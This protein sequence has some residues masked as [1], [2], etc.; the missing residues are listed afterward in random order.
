MNWQRFREEYGESPEEHY[1]DPADYQESIGNVFE[2]NR[3]R[4]RREEEPSEGEEEEAGEVSEVHIRCCGCDKKIPIGE[5]YPSYNHPEA[6]P[7]CFD[8]LPG[9]IKK[10][11]E[12]KRRSRHDR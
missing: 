6:P 3:I 4:K 1:D 7:V 2:A 9:E 10:E 5:A 12:E 8:C 11:L